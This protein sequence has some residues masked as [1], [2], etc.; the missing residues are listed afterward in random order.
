MTGAAERLKE[1]FEQ[2]AAR[3]DA[4]AETPSS[5]REPLRFAAGLFRAQGRAASEV[6]SEHE[7]GALTGTLERLVQLYEETGKKDQSDQWRKKLQKAKNAGKP[8]IH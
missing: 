3:A 6:L 4:L 5:G 8:V 2:R 7:R 1:K